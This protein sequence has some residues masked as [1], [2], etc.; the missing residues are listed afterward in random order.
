LSIVLAESIAFGNEPSQTPATFTGCCD[1][2][3]ADQNVYLSEWLRACKAD[4]G[5]NELTSEI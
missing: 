1:A 4:H 5:G 3:A 2:F